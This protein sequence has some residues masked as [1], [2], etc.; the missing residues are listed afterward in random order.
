MLMVTTAYKK[1]SFIKLDLNNWTDVTNVPPPPPFLTGFGQIRKLTLKRT[2]GDVS[3]P[4]LPSPPCGAATDSDAN[5]YYACAWGI[6]VK[7]EN[8]QMVCHKM[9]TPEEV[10]CSSTHR[11]LLTILY[12]TVQFRSI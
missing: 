1:R 2:G 6:L 9:F 7:G 3:S 5:A 12:N 8:R 4:V 11:E 10:S